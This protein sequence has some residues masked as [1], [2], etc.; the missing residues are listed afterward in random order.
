MFPFSKKHKH[1]NKETHEKEKVQIHVNMHKKN[2]KGIQMFQMIKT[3]DIELKYFFR[4]KEKMVFML[5]FD[6]TSVSSLKSK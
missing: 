4:K 3:T 6:I 2:V 5:N 1:V